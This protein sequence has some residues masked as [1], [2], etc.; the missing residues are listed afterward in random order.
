[1]FKA[2]TPDQRPTLV[3]IFGEQSNS[4]DLTELNDIKYE[5]NDN[6]LLAVRV[7]GEYKNR[8]FFLNEKYNWEIGKDNYGVLVLVPTR[9]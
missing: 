9:K 5:I 7:N 2:A 8:G 3:N 1:M 6:D 4:V